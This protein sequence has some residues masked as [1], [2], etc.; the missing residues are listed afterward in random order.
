MMLTPYIGLTGL[1]LGVE[2]VEG[3]LQSLVR[4]LAGIDGASASVGHTPKNLGPDQRAPV[5]ARATS[6]SDR[7]RFPA[8]RKPRSV[9]STVWLRP[10]HWRTRRDPGDSVSCRLR[11]GIRSSGPDWARA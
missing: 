7:Y 2:G 11:R 6:D 8:C 4:G 10:C 9:T 3:L 1:P 5:M